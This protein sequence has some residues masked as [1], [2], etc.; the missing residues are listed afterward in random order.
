M[1]NLSNLTNARVNALGSH[2]EF[3]VVYDQ[4]TG[5]IIHVHLFVS[6]DGSSLSPEVK[7]QLARE[8]AM[9]RLSHAK[10]TIAAVATLHVGNDAL[11][12]GHAYQVDVKTATIVQRPPAKPL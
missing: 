3:T 1:S 6:H 8:T 7:N 4:A 2:N 9:H 11:V 10:R 5:E 12:P